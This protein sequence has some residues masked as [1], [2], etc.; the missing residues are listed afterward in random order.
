MSRKWITWAGGVAVSLALAVP[1]VAQYS[2]GSTSSSP[3]TRSSQGSQQGTSGTT[4]GKWRLG[5][6]LMNVTVAGAQLERN[7]SA[8]RVTRLLK[9]LI[10]SA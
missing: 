6:P 2:S 5:E 1:A 4:T 7:G 8:T 10:V 3:S 9:V